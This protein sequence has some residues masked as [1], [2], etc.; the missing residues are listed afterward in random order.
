M[1]ALSHAAHEPCRPGGHDWRDREGTPLLRRWRTWSAVL[2]GSLILL[3]GCSGASVAEDAPPGIL[4]IESHSDGDAVDDDSVQITGTAP[5]G[6]EIVL[7]ISFG[8]DKRTSADAD[9]TWVMTVDLDEGDNDLTFRIG[10]DEATS[11]TIRIVYGPAVAAEPSPTPDP[12]TPPT[13]EP[14]PAPTDNAAAAALTS[15]AAH[16]AVSST[17]IGEGLATVAEDAGNLDIEALQL[18]SVDLWLQIGDEVD[19]LAGHTAHPCYATL[20]ERYTGAIDVLYDALD[21]ISD[22]ALGY[23]VDLLEQGADRMLEGSDLITAIPPIVE[24]AREACEA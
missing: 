14:T 24:T 11:K 3:A 17:V 1:T 12:T 15:Y 6:S 16:V 4:S 13:P 10:D 5:A 22:G 9:G 2:S 18:S 20:H 21:L 23:D 8:R 19:W 7:D